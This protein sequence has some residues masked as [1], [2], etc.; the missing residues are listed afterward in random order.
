MHALA[1]PA[2]GCAAHHGR[3]SGAPAPAALNTARAPS[4]TA[5][6]T[7]HSAPMTG[8][9]AATAEE[10]D[11]PEARRTAGIAAAA[12]TKATRVAMRMLVE[13]IGE[14]TKSQSLVLLDVFGP[15][16]LHTQ[17][18]TRL[19]RQQNSQTPFSGE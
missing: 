16:P 12:A 1:A 11:D 8:S 19:S 14:G 15:C 7:V 5:K 9:A 2:A 17:L 4:R 18:Q 3:Q 10:E 6:L 13:K